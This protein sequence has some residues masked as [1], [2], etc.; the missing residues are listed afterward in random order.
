MW[1]GHACLPAFDVDFDVARKERPRTRLL[2]QN[3]TA[4][5]AVAT[6]ALRLAVAQAVANRVSGR[7]HVQHGGHT[8]QAVMAGLV[9]DIA[10]AGHARGFAREVSYQSSR[11]AAEYARDRIQ[12]LTSAGLQVVVRHYKIAGAGEQGSGE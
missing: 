10:E 1:G 5:A 8:L 4:E 11:A 12:F 9:E 2:D 6:P 3:L 7:C